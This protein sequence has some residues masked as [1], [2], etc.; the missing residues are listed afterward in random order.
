M[1][2]RYGGEEFACLLPETNAA[3]AMAVA[4]RMLECIRTLNIEH[5]A[6]DKKIVTLVWVFVP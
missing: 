2:F 4:T 6:S 3:G 1:L 5:P